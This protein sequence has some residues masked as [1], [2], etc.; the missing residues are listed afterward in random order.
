MSSARLISLTEVKKGIK[1][2]LELG[3][4][5]TEVSCKKFLKMT[6]IH[7]Y[8]NVTQNNCLRLNAYTQQCS[9]NHNN[10]I[11]CVASHTLNTCMHEAK[12]RPY[13]VTWTGGES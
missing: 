12:R 13:M 11:L 6:Y 7:I 10:I 3:N 1:A 4:Y 5:K 2:G 8:G 9:R